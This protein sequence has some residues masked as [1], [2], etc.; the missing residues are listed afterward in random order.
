MKCFAGG[1]EEE[2]CLDLSE[3]V[4]ILIIPYLVKVAKLKSQ[5]KQEVKDKPEDFDNDYEYNN[6]IE[7]KKT[8][9]L[10]KPENPDIV[11]DMLSIILFEATGCADNAKLDAELLKDI[12]HSFGED[13]LAEDEKLIEDMIV[14][15]RGGISDDTGDDGIVLNTDTFLHA[16]TADVDKYDAINETRLTTYFQ[17]VFG[18]DNQSYELVRSKDVKYMCDDEEGD[19]SNDDKSR[20]SFNVVFTASAIDTQADTYMSSA[21]SIILWINFI[22]TYF[23]YFLSAQSSVWLRD[24]STWE[25]QFPC[26]LS[27]SLILWIINWVKLT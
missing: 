6:Y 21:I 10:L 20:P 4:A 17:D 13:E 3:L 5:N 15:A 7:T 23:A 12:F 2:E 11:Q 14:A 22:V 25:R 24:C 26:Y 8:L 27:N 19:N 18:V 9:D 1:D 16:L